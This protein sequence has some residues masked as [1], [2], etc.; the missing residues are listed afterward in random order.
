MLSS[1]K[2]DINWV[3]TYNA[4]MP[5]PLRPFVLLHHALPGAGHWDLMLDTGEGLATW[6]LLDDPRALGAGGAGG[7]LRARRLE[8]HRRAYLDYEGPVS[9]D[10]GHVARVDHGDHEVLERGPEGWTVRLAGSMLSGTFR[11]AAGAGPDAPWTFERIS[12]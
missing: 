11:C 8:D 4:A 6:Q 9:A 5:Q 7:A 1:A 2:A 10:R 12:D 3:S